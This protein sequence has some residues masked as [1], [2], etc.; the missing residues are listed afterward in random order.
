MTNLSQ[1][2][3][4]RISVVLH[5][6]VGPE[7]TRVDLIMQLNLDRLGEE[8]QKIDISLGYL[9][10]LLS[11]GVLGVP[12]DTSREPQRHARM[13]QIAPQRRELHVL[14]DVDHVE[15]RHRC[16]DGAHKTSCEEECDEDHKYTKDALEQMLRIHLHGARE[17]RNCPVQRNKVLFLQVSNI[18]LIL[19]DPAVRVLIAGCANSEPQASDDM[20]VDDDHCRAL[21]NLEYE[22]KSF[23]EDALRERA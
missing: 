11:G 7:H 2:H 19:S 1:T 12:H 10:L 5:Q 8:V 17:L 21:G 14:L 16:G 3:W 23:G 18:K 15:P 6:R 22:D 20:S 13:P 4:L 9:S